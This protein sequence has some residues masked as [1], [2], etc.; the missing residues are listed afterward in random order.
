MHM[1]GLV[2]IMSP[3]QIE[4]SRGAHILVFLTGSFFF[5]QAHILAVM[6]DYY[7]NNNLSVCKIQ[8]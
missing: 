5:E 7:R 8:E 1:V 6:C 3:S 4:G 2:Y